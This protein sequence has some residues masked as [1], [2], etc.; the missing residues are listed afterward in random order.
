MSVVDYFH[1]SERHMQKP[2]N[3]QTVLYIAPGIAYAVWALGWPDGSA[4]SRWA[5]GAC[6]FMVGMYAGQWV[7]Q[8]QTERI[9]RRLEREIFEAEQM[10]H[11]T[12][13][14][15]PTEL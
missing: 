8:M 5:G 1:R 10:P 7:A 11:P 4:F 9:L 2:S 3:I 13:Y 6:A 15:G 12:Q 14:R